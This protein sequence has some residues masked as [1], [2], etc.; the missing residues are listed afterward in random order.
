MWQAT[1]N[2]ELIN[3]KLSRK[4]LRANTGALGLTKED[5]EQAM[6]IKLQNEKDLEKKKANA[7]L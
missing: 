4:R 3:K 1:R 5:A 2:K 6:I 7:G